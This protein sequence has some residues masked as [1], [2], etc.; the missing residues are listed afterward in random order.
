[1]DSKPSSN[2]W[3]NDWDFDEQIVAVDNDDDDDNNTDKP[4]EEHNHND[5]N[6]NNNIGVVDDESNTKR[7]EGM[8]QEPNVTSATSTP[9]VTLMVQP[10]VVCE[11]L[12]ANDTNAIQ[13]EKSVDLQPELKVDE[14]LPKE[15]VVSEDLPQEWKQ[16]DLDDM[17]D[18][19]DDD[20]DDDD[21][22]E[23]EEQDLSKPAVEE[24][25][26]I[27][28]SFTGPPEPKTYATEDATLELGEPVE[29]EPNDAPNDVPNDALFMHEEIVM[30]SNATTINGRTVQTELIQS[31]SDVLIESEETSEPNRGPCPPDNDS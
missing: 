11:E 27:D 15:S 2:D 29:H 28:S 30:D 5:D 18:D 7:Q 16:D 3:D 8:A 1:V 4:H 19:E 26:T 6:N 17:Y 9:P 14:D 23:T 12:V 31:Q 24:S 10:Q 21:S 13:P 25:N 20:N 22:N